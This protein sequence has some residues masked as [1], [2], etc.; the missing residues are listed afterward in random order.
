MT[1]VRE[2]EACLFEL[3]PKT[4]AQ[5]WDNVGLL[6]GETGAAVQKVLVALDITAQVVREA[7][8]LGCGLIVA[9]H[10]VMN[11]A[12]HPV[13]TIRDD[14]AQGRLLMDLLRSGIAAVCM[15]TNLDAAAGGVNDALAAT[16]G[17]TGAVPAEENGIERIGTLPF[18]MEL[19]QFLSHVKERLDANGLRYT[20]GGRSVCRVAVGGGACGD[21]FARAAA[22]G[23]DTFVT[24]DVKY[25]QFLDAAELGMNLIDAGHFPTENVVCPVLAETIRSRFPELE[26]VISRRHR[27]VIRYFL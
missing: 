23:C 16:L 4:L 21:F 26:V 3:A 2:I 24:A 18:P 19:E 9:H 27:E 14:D 11:C 10:P 13:Q 1:T 17:L 6:V 20:G 12:W 8:D 22:L 15:H 7:A 25:N 5:S